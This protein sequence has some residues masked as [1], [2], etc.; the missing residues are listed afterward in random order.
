MTG[1]TP[2]GRKGESGCK[3]DM[4]NISSE[5]DDDNRNGLEGEGGGR[6]G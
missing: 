2:G 4:E 3:E 6:G 1:M 5:R